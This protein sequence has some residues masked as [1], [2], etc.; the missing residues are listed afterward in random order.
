MGQIHDV[1]SVMVDGKW[2]MKD[3]KVLNL[4]EEYIVTEANKIAKK[5]WGY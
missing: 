2:I 4:D 3:H 1:E 5:A